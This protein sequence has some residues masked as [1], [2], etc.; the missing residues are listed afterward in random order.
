MVTASRRGV[1]MIARLSTD[2]Q[3]D[4]AFGGGGLAPVQLGNSDW[5]EQV[6]PA[7]GASP[8]VVLRNGRIRLALAFKGPRGRGYR[9]GLV[10]LTKTGHPDR[11]FGVR[12]RAL[13]PRPQ[14]A[15]SGEAIRTAIGDRRGGVLVAGTFWDGRDLSLD[16]SAVVRRF[17]ADG[18]LDRSF[19]RRGVVSTPPAAGI[20]YP[21][22]EQ[23]L[24]LA[25]DRLVVGQHTWD[26]KYGFW[27]DATLRLLH[28]G[29]DDDPPRVSISVYGCR[30]V[31]V[32][33][34]D[35]SAL[36]RV[37]V[38]AG[39]RVIRRSSQKRFRVRVRRG[40]R[41]ISV[42]ATDLARNSSRVSVRL[43]RC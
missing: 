4:R 31:R 1:P 6:H 9:M 10:G 40:T 25:G 28:A 8:A 29:Y 18:T 15:D 38:R 27:S 39:R 32:R 2:G 19:G 42:R 11:R 13:G 20:G 17:R 7:Y 34:S 37:V 33:V 22:I 3:L 14:P 23:Q 21:V 26:G 5:R 12:G 43:P 41:R 24:A 36:D 16:S 35:L 30:S